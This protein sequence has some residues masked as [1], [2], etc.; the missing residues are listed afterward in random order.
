VNGV[1]FL[2]HRRHFLTV[3][4]DSGKEWGSGWCLFCKDINPIHGGSDLTI[5]TPKASHMFR[6]ENTDIQII[7]PPFLLNASAQNGSPSSGGNHATPTTTPAGCSLDS[8]VLHTELPLHCFLGHLI[9]DQGQT[10]I[11]C[12]KGPGRSSHRQCRRD[13]SMTTCKQTHV[14]L[15]DNHLMM[16][17]TKSFNLFLDL[18]HHWRK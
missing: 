10:E 6:G 18:C 11:C 1:Q 9:P 12:T 13:H 14:S 15:G 2:V 4:S 7:L 16:P 5:I 3:S 8:S 17:H